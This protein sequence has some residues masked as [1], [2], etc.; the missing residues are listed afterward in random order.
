MKISFYCLA[1]VAYLS[2]V[3]CYKGFAI[4]EKVKDELRKLTELIEN[5]Q[6]DL[7]VY[8]DYSIIPATTTTTTT[9]TTEATTK[10]TTTTT[11]AATV[12]SKR[13][14]TTT[15]KRRTNSELNK[16]YF[17][18]Q[19][20]KRSVHKRILRHS[21]NDDDNREVFED[22]D[23]NRRGDVD[24]SNINDDVDLIERNDNDNPQEYTASDDG[25]K[26]EGINSLIGDDE[27]DEESEKA[28]NQRKV[29]DLLSDKE[30]KPRT[31]ETDDVDDE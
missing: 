15:K 23:R 16:R 14:I 22:T 25:V 29:E 5:E 4:L 24:E 6:Q 10:T 8:D 18:L 1:I 7:Y 9:T 21:S 20:L 11:T 28:E 17:P 3:N 13:T 31:I 2:L 26:L 19:Y 12:N 27:N 30:D